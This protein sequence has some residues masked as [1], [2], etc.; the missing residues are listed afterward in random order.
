M[1]KLFFITVLLL[2]AGIGFCQYHYD[3][4]QN[5]RNAYNEIINLKFTEG[6]KIIEHEKTA[7]PG[8]NIPY[9][10][11]NYI[12][13]LTIFIAEEEATFNFYDDQKDNIIE[14]LKEGNENSPYYRY[15]LAQT[16]LQWAV[17]R[18]KFKEYA[19]A[20]IEINKAYRLLEENNEEHP[21]FLPNLINLGLLHTFIGTIPDNYNW[22]KKLIGIEGTI[23]QGVNEILKVLNASL[24]NKEMSHFKPECLFYLSFIQSNLSTNKQKALDYIKIIEADPA[25]LRSPLAIYAV[26]QIYSDNGMNDKAIDLLLTRPTGAEYF[27]FY[28]LDYLTGLAKLHRLDADADKFLFKY[29]IN[30]KGVNYIKETY[31]KLAWFY[32]VNENTA[33]YKEYMAKVL[34]FGNS[35]VDADIQAQREAERGVVPNIYLLRARLL[36]DGGYYDKALIAI[37]SSKSTGFLLNS[38]DSLEFTYRI[39]RIYHEWGKPDNSIE[40][41]NRTIEQGSESPYYFAA[42]SALQ[43]GMIYEQKSDYTKAFHYYELAQSMDNEEYRNSINQKAKAGIHRIENRK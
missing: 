30:F 35:V 12:Y 34:Q 32:L 38:R 39:G 13:F 24:T 7:N 25:G 1:Q 20:A 36:C 15:C 29:I 42:N 40:F 3:F 37:T 10:L 11:D 17:A 6:K 14:R 21:D 2:S 41:Y 9:L 27:P 4:N 18:G 28:F 33:K 22:V 26:S 16:Y 19:T 31:Q 5:C 8:N 23:D 43:L